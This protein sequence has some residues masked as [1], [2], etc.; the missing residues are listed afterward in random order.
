MRGNPFVLVN[1]IRNPNCIVCVS[2]VRAKTTLNPSTRVH[3]ITRFS[4]DHTHARLVESVFWS[5]SITTVVAHR[6]LT[7]ACH[8]V[9]SSMEKYF[10]Q[11]RLRHTNV[12]LR[13]TWSLVFIATRIFSCVQFANNSNADDISSLT[14]PFLS[15]NT[16][17][18]FL[19]EF[20]NLP[21]L[22][23]QIPRESLTNFSPP[24]TNTHI[25]FPP[26]SSCLKK[27]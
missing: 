19:R 14:C 24:I 2:P 6:Q 4:I 11:H 5:A 3:I 20:F 22:V 27:N 16:R 18:Q 12:R 8:V 21:L 23:P 13:N 10:D 7:M 9:A 17:S 25:L 15:A 1:M 26:F